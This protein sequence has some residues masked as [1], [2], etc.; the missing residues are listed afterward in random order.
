M[1]FPTKQIGRKLRDRTGQATVEAAF[2]IPVLLT[3]VLLLIQPAIVCYDLIVM[4]SACAEACRL[5]SEPGSNDSA[6]IQDFVKRKLSAVPQAEIFHMHDGGCSWE[7][8]ID[9]LGSKT[10]TVT[11]KNK[12]KVLP[13]IDVGLHAFGALGDKGELEIQASSTQTSQPGWV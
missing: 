3:V 7:V 2:M 9:G 12:L 5:A 10:A 1:R 13:L 6:Y 11:V 8:S 4:K